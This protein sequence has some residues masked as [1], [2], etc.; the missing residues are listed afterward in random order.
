MPVT[1]LTMKS[2]IPIW[3]TCL[4]YQF[5]SFTVSIT[6]STFWIVGWFR[7]CKHYILRMHSIQA[8]HY[9]SH[10]LHVTP[11]LHTFA[12]FSNSLL[13]D[14][15]INAALLSYQLSFWRFRKKI[16]TCY[17]F[18]PHLLRIIQRINKMQQLIIFDILNWSSTKNKSLSTHIPS[19][20]LPRNCSESESMAVS[21]SPEWPHG[22][23]L[24]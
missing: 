13:Q 8:F 1:F 21:C 10:V 15:T 11:V 5:S 16:I 17:S 6:I 4:Q 19:L 3:N 12:M 23:D 2:K 14:S 7:P 9:L 22:E 18:T 24:I 20:L